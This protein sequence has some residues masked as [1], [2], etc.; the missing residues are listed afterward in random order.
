MRLRRLP[1]ASSS[2]SAISRS[3][4]SAVSIRSWSWRKAVAAAAGIICRPNLWPG[5]KAR[6]ALRITATSIASC[7]NAPATGDNRPTAAKNIAVP[8]IAM[9]AIMLCTAMPRVR[10]AMATAS[11][12]R[13]S[14]SVRMTTSA[15]SDEALAPLAP[16]AMPTP[17]AARCGRI[18]DAVTDHQGWVQALL[19]RHCVDLIGRLSV[20]KHSIKIE[21]CPNGLCGIHSV[22]SQHHDPRHSGRPKSLNGT[23]CLTP[24]LVG[25]Q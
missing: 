18:I 22:T 1:T 21:C 4:S 20:C 5:V 17:A 12:T 11:E 2:A 8:D 3:R 14:R 10:F 16:M 9:P 13:S 25:E 7:V 19:G 24:K 15:A 6:S 23:R